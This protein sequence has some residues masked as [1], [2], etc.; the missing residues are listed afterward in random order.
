M[1]TCCCRFR[2]ARLNAAGIVAMLQRHQ[3]RDVGYFA[4]GRFE[5]FPP[6]M[7]T[8]RDPPAA[9]SLTALA[10]PR[11]FAWQWSGLDRLDTESA[12]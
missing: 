2:C 7:R 9:V 8:E 12:F 6:P 1:V 5:Q 4:P 3:A 10:V 11:A